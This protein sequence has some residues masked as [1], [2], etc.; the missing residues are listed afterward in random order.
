MNK[1]NKH[2]LYLVPP[3]VTIEILEP[4]NQIIEERSN[5]PLPMLTLRCSTVAGQPPQLIAVHWYRNG[6]HFLTTVSFRHF[7]TQKQEQQQ[8]Q[9]TLS[10]SSS[11]LYSTATSTPS[12]LH[13]SYY[14]R[15]GTGKHFTLIDESTPLAGPVNGQFLLSINGTMAQP[16][17]HYLNQ[18]ELLTIANI[19]KDHAGNY[20]CLGFNG[21]TNASQLSKELLITVKCKIIFN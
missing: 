20:S 8:Q 3:V 9:S 15:I 11:P 7:Q 13:H 18:P 6:R 10:S 2:F 4:K 16:Y 12:F 17:V 5:R 21:A 19:T 1:K 14:H